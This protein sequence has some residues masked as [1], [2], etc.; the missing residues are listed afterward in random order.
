MCLSSGKPR[1]DYSDGQE[2]HGAREPPVATP[3]GMLMGIRYIGYLC[4]LAPSRVFVCG[5]IKLCT[6]LTIFNSPS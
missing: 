2:S 4:C 5:P 6:D 3:P 1:R